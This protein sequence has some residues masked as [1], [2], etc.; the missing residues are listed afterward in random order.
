MDHGPSHTNQHCLDVSIVASSLS[1]VSVLGV[2]PSGVKIEISQYPDPTD[3]KTEKVIVTV[4]EETS[5]IHVYINVINGN[6]L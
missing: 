5:F 6:V 1:D 3:R 4:V 2:I